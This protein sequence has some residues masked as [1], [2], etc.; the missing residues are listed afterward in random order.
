MVRV[1][2]AVLA[3]VVALG[4]S[5]GNEPA[6]GIPVGEEEPSG[7]REVMPTIVTGTPTGAF[8]VEEK[9]R[10]VPREEL[11]SRVMAYGEL[12]P[13]DQDNLTAIANTVDAPCAPCERRS[14]A[15]CV[16]EMPDGCENLP[17]LLDRTVLLTKAGVPPGKI[18][19]AVLYTD[20]W[21]PIPHDDRPVDGVKTGMPLDVWVDPATA[22]VHAV[23]QTLD[24]L[25]LRGVA[26]TF[27]IAPLSDN[28][29][30][31]AWSAAAI[32]AESQGKLE[33][34][35]R[36]IRTWRE[37]QRAVQGSLHLEVTPAD[38]EVLAAAMSSEG[39]D[40]SR[41]DADRTSVAVS[42]RIDADVAL[43]NTLGVRV[44]PSWFADGY[45]LR[46]A[47]SAFAIQRVINLERPGHVH[48][49][50]SGLTGAD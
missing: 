20:I 19:E 31:R 12:T 25:D 49:S 27:R 37:E 46:G 45:R 16:V 13:L 41:F 8:P 17:E 39:L 42:E 6:V 35:L 23:T 1:A 10:V 47:Q 21:L 30:H 4:S 5:C 11:V 14:L 15:A 33:P 38:L 36:A 3:P 44:A 34:F 7:A 28:P 26:I 40:K 22:S 2:L 18:R 9:R 24:E 32:A 50:Q 43:A 48:A 29:A